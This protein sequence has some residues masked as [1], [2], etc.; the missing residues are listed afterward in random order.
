MSVTPIKYRRAIFDYKERCNSLI[1][2]TKEIEER[3]EIKFEQVGIDANHAHYLLSSNPKLAPAK[4]IQ[5]SSPRTFCRHPDLKK[6][7]WGGQLCSDGNNRPRR[8]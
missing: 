5:I 4:I 1:L 8:K 6:E 3:Y 2:I 7:L